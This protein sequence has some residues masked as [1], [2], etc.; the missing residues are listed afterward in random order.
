MRRHDGDNNKIN[1][2]GTGEGVRLRV[3]KKGKDYSTVQ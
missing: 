2:A 1:Q 3:C